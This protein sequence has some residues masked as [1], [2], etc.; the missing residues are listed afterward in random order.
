MAPRSITFQPDTASPLA[1]EGYPLA[2]LTRRMP[3]NPE[4]EEDREPPFPPSPSSVVSLADGGSVLRSAT[5]MD[6][7]EASAGGGKTAS[8]LVI[9]DNPINRVSMR[10]RDRIEVERALGLTSSLLPPPPSP[11]ARPRRLLDEEAPHL[12]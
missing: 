5:V 3:S 7:S 10:R 4:E 8:C 9:E 11:P 6:E 1:H 12:R 2:H